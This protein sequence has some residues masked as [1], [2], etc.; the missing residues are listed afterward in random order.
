M[1]TLTAVVENHEARSD[2]HADRIAKVETISSDL[3]VTMARVDASAKASESTKRWMIATFISMIILAIAFLT[4][5]FKFTG[6]K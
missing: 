1:A 5:A 4:F 2:N 6:G 3:R